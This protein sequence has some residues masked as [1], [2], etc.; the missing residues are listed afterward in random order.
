MKI[1]MIFECGPQGAD[2]QVCE[3]LASQGYV[4]LASPS[5]GVDNKGMTADRVGTDAQ[6]G[7]I[8]FLINYAATIGEA[9]TT[10]VGIVGFSWGGLSNALAAVGCDEAQGYY[11]SRPL[12]PDAFDHWLATSNYEA[13]RVLVAGVTA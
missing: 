4:V 3:Y 9:D 2:K 10:R 6:V 8:H 1:G 12:L 13:S 5:Q 7:D 11:L